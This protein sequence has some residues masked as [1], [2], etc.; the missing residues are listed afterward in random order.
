MM[1]KW[2]YLSYQLG[3]KTPAYGGGKSFCAHQI[4]DMEK[5]DLCHTQHWSFSNHLG[6]HIDFPKHFARGGKISSDYHPGFWFFSLPFFLD[7]SNVAPGC[8][9]QPEDMHLEVVPGNVDILILKTGFSIYRGQDIYWEKNPGFAPELAGLFREQFPN[10]RVFGFDSISLSSFANRETGRQ[11]HKAFLDHRRPIL[12]LE[13]MDLSAVNN[14]MRLEQ[15]I[16][17]PLRVENAD[18]S[19]CT[20]FVKIFE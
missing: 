1:R 3:V 12:L 14:S 6:T 15:V 20:V 18:G 7:H 11:A 5:G 9:I 10:L 13:D 8:I 16:I 19:P 17:S 2:I 4:K